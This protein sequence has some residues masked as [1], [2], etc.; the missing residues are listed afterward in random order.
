MGSSKAAKRRR[1][2][3]Q[4][5]GLVNVSPQRRENAINDVHD[6]AILRPKAR[7]RNRRSR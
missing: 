4:R 5:H 1:R 3:A 7:K 6:Q 2:V